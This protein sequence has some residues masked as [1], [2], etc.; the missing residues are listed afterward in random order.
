MTRTQSTVPVPLTVRD[1]MIREVV[2][3]P[4][5]ATVLEAI[6]IMNRHRIGAVL[7]TEE[8]QLLGIFTERD[9]LRRM[10]QEHDDWHHIPV[11]EWMT[12]NPWT[13]SPE[14]TWEQVLSLIET[15]G[16]RHVPVVEEGR[17]VGIV[18]AR[19]LI[20]CSHECLQAMV[21]ERTQALER[22]NAKLLARE[23]EVELHMR[24][25]GEL[26]ARLLPRE[27][28]HLPG[29]TWAVHYAPLDPLG[30]DYYDFARP[31]SHLL[32]ILLADAC[33]HSIPAAMLMIMAHTAFRD[34]AHLLRSPAMVLEQMNRY[35]HGIAQE[36]FV[37]AFY[38]V[39]DTNTLDLH[40]AGAG[41]PVPL[42]Y[43]AST[44]R[45]ELLESRGLMLGISADARYQDSTTAIRPGDRLLLYTDGTVDCR[46]ESGEPYGV[47]RLGQFLQAHAH[48]EAQELVEALVNDLYTFLGRPRGCDDMTILA[49]AFSG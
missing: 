49:G 47:T 34:A 6:G 31:S 1:M 30:G 12:P 5:T 16:I 27:L 7:V 35:L 40:F 9:V 15:L 22:I 11:A 43:R 19:D 33:G 20:A 4:P 37:T 13:V 25:A 18:T 38:A 8:R 28:P 29:V 39:L 41:H 42:M 46:N 24:V 14:A 44:K 26:Q 17:L 3:V 45:I 32:G 48:L 10:S 23:R 21:A 2:T 36:H